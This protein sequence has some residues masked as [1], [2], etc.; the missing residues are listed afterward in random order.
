MSSVC[1]Y[2]L[3]CLPVCF[4]GLFCVCAACLPRA[5]PFLHIRLLSALPASACYL[6]YTFACFHLYLSMFPCLPIW[7]TSPVTA[8][9][10]VCSACCVFVCSRLL[11]HA[12]LPSLHALL[13]ASACSSPRHVCL[14]VLHCMPLCAT[15]CA[16][17]CSL[18]CYCV[19]QCLFCMFPCLPLLLPIFAP[20]C[21][22]AC[23][24]V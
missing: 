10:Y 23:L 8:Y 6:V 11:L 7:A 5:L 2:V 16:Y 24:C 20:A 12:P 3:P 17:V 1:L 14:C 15:S 13:P 21:F 9:T 22:L 4:L 19:L 18:V